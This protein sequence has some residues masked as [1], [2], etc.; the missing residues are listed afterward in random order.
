[1]IDA[2]ILR[3]DTLLQYVKKTIYKLENHDNQWNINGLYG[4][5]NM[6]MFY[7]IIFAPKGTYPKKSF[8]KKRVGNVKALPKKMQVYADNNLMFYVDGD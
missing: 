5:E 4:K 2:S 3:V 1:M 6:I 7:R 8:M